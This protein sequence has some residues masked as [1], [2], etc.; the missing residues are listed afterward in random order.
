MAALRGRIPIAP[1]RPMEEAL[2]HDELAGRGM[3]AEYEHPS[4]G[5]VRSVGLPLTMGGFDPQYARGPGL[6]SDGNAIL[7][8]LGYT[9][10]AISDLRD[11]GAFGADGAPPTEPGEAG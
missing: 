1:V 4:F 3:L 6:G 9:P 7:G 11:A 2:D 10:D 5:T 8:E